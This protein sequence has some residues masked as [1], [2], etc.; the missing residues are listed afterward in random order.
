MVCLPLMGAS[1]NKK[2]DIDERRCLDYIQRKRA[3]LSVAPA[4][5]QV[6]RD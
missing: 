6:P 5:G 1:V 3:G 4:L 2:R